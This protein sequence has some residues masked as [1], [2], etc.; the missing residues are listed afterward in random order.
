MLAAKGLAASRN[1]Q[2]H[3]IR[4]NLKS[5]VANPVCRIPEPAAN[6]KIK[7]HDSERRC[8]Y[9]KSKIRNLISTGSGANR[10]SAMGNSASPISVANYRNR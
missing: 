4:L 2:R 1:S 9:R 10:Q 6:R 3:W 8:A 7:I 5:C